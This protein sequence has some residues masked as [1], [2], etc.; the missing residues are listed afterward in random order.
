MQCQSTN[1]INFNSIANSHNIY[2]TLTEACVSYFACPDDHQPF[3]LSKILTLRHLGFAQVEYMQINLSCQ[4][5]LLYP[6]NIQVKSITS[7][8]WRGALPPVL[9]CAIF[10]MRFEG[11]SSDGT[12]TTP[13]S[14]PLRLVHPTDK[15]DEF[16]TAVA[17]AKIV[18]D[19]RK[20]GMSLVHISRVM[21][22]N[23]IHC[24]VRAKSGRR[25]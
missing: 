7:C 20:R 25:K 17:P 5:C 24:L 16:S 19:L 21:E 6:S 8:L 10:Q 11:R 12:S 18:G 13:F 23:L 2:P 9:I 1:K 14:T 4:N 15:L 22:T 3:A